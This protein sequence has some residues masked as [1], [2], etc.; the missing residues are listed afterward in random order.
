M[1]ILNGKKYDDKEGTSHI[2]V[3]DGCNRL[4]KEG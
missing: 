4:G 1:A 2:L 3:P